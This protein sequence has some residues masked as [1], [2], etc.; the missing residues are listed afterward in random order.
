VVLASSGWGGFVAELR[1][2]DADMVVAF[3]TAVA[4]LSSETRDMACADVA[5]G[6][7]VNSKRWI[8]DFRSSSSSHIMEGAA[9]VEAVDDSVPS[10]PLFV[11]W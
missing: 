11:S 3:V 10:T 8:R 7:P 9:V 4:G 6:L 1:F 2:G 5:G